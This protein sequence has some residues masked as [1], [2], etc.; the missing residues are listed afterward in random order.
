MVLIPQ[1][2]ISQLKINLMVTVTQVAISQATQ[3]AISQATQVE[4]SLEAVELRAVMIMEIRAAMVIIQEMN[5]EM[6]ILIH[7]AAI[8]YQIPQIII[9]RRVQR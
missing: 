4:V 1:T 5:L 9:R 3:V 6:E 7:Q 2:A 8:L